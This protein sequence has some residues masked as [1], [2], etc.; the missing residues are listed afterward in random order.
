K[1]S[2]WEVKPGQKIS[3]QAAASD[4]DGNSITYSWWQYHEVDT[5]AGKVTLDDDKKATLLFTVPA[6]AKAGDDI[7][8]IL[9]ATDTGTPA[10]TRY[11]RVVLKVR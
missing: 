5:Y 9:S 6:D 10:L 1:Q 11:A 7:H 8:I 3:L 4:P 2:K